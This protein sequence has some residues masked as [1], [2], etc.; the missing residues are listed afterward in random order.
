MSSNYVYYPGLTELMNA[1]PKDS[2]VSRTIHQ[3]EQMKVIVFGFDQGQE[4]SEHTASVPA[5]IQILQ[6]NCRLTVGPDSYQAGPGAW[7]HMAAQLKHSVYAETL[8]VMLLM[9]FK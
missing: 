6:G 5:I 3:D 2:I 7:V 8:V 1:I 4:L 9:M